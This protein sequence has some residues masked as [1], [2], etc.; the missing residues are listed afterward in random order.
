MK[1]IFRTFILLCLLFK[2]ESYA[3]VT[4]KAYLSGKTDHS[5]I[6]IKFFPASPTAKLD[7]V[8][9]SSDGTYSLA[10]NGGIYTVSF[11]KKGY[12]SFLY[13]SNAKFA[14]A[15]KDSL[16]AVTLEGGNIVNVR[17]AVSGTWKKDS[18]YVVEGDVTV[19]V[20]K[21]LV[22]EP[23]TTIM[24][25]GYYKIDVFGELIARGTSTDSITFSSAK[26]VPAIGDWNGI[27][28]NDS[29]K[30]NSCFYF[31]NFNYA[32][33]S[34]EISNVGSYISNSTMRYVKCGIIVRGN[35][36]YV[37]NNTICD[38]YGDAGI[39]IS[40]KG[41]RIECNKIYNGGTGIVLGDS[42]LVKNNTIYSMAF[43]SNSYSQFN[44]KIQLN[45]IDYGGGIFVTNG[46]GIIENNFIHDCLSGISIIYPG[47][48][49]NQLPDPLIVGNTLYKNAIGINSASPVDQGGIKNNIISNNIWSFYLNHVS[50]DDNWVPEKVTSNL[51]WNNEFDSI[52]YNF[53]GKI[54]SKNSNG[55]PIDSY[56]NVI[57]DPLFKDGM[58]PFLTGSSPAHGGGVGGTDIGFN[59]EYT[60]NLDFLYT[61]LSGKVHAGANLL[62]H[63]VVLAY[64]KSSLDTPV[65]LTTV[66]N[67]EFKFKNVD[68]GEYLLYAIPDTSIG[69]GYFPTFYVDKLF[70][71]DANSVFVIANT[72]DVDIFLSK[73]PQLQKGSAVVAGNIFH[74]DEGKDVNTLYNRSWF[75]GMIDTVSADLAVR[76]LPVLLCNVAGTPLAWTLT[77]GKGNFR[78]DSLPEN[79]YVLNVQRVGY[80]LEP[81]D[82]I[83]LSAGHMEKYVNGKLV[84]DDII[85]ATESSILKSASY[86]VFPN[87]VIDVLT[88]ESKGISSEIDE[89][90]ISDPMGRTLLSE[91]ASP[92][93]AAQSIKL[94]MRDMPSGMYI[95]KIVPGSG[96]PR[97]FTV[98]R[99]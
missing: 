64:N 81:L 75:A 8:Y 56:F 60:C 74:G 16:N 84:K 18:L 53:V 19:P 1:N 46:K 26:N 12:K 68:T 5:G 22:I 83:N 37:M 72:Y 10:L 86:S 14:I 24:F 13:N 93:D 94:D 51:L 2:M 3:Q 38:F 67:G 49:W 57:A 88:I 73:A 21:S 34:V 95:L 35:N 4:G 77:D 69:L 89:V 36:S 20:G 45:L 58:P 87:P 65:Q 97:L 80:M 78:F 52:D 40:A 39:S 31:C 17:D 25:N 96:S 98:I 7:S 82:T 54:V 92:A 63:G 59:P 30:S 70:P 62:P 90:T 41:A 23:G 55:D 99:Q 79:K 15:T 50:E 48:P 71:K 66:K 9:T 61:S 43:D 76:N 6:K 47:P 91:M 42:S 28:L 11:T 29:A 44:R 32:A 33:Y 27:V 85:A